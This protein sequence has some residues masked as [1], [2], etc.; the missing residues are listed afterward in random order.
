[1]TNRLVEFIKSNVTI[2]TSVATFVTT[3]VGG[4]LFVDER[5]AHAAE[6]TQQQTTQSRAIDG[7][8]R[9]TAV[10]MEQLQLNSLDDKIFYIEQKEKKTPADEAQLNRFNRQRH[11]TAERIRMLQ[12]PR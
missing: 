12:Q 9:D 6:I 10:Q 1:M 5:Y 7:L 4:F 3:V 2:V 8:R 11:D